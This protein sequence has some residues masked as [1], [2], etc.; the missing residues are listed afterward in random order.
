[1]GF[2]YVTEEGTLGEVL[3]RLERARFVYLDIETTASEDFRKS[4]VRLLQLGDDEETFVVDLFECPSCAQRLKEVLNKKAWVGHNLRFD[5]KHLYY[6]FGMQP[7]TTFDTY[8]AS[9]L[10]GNERNSLQAV[11]EKYLGEYL[12]KTEQTSNWGAS[13]LSRQQI[14]YA[15]KDVEILRRLFPILLKELNA[16]TSQRR[17][18]LLKTQ[19]AEIFGLENPVAIVEMAAVKHV[20]KLEAHGFALDVEVLKKLLKELK[21]KLQKAQI[22]FI[23]RYGK[24]D[25]FSSK[26]VAQFLTKRLGLSLPSTKKGNVSTDDKALSEYLEVP[27]VAEIVKIRKMKKTYDKIREL[28][29]YVKEDGRVYPEFKQIGAKTGR[30]SSSEP[31]VQNIPRDLRKIFK[32]PEGRLLVIADFSQIELRI[33]AEFVNEERMI[34]AFRR[35]EDMHV[36]T[37]SLVLGKQKDEVTKEERQLAKAMNYGLIYGISPRGLMEYAKFGYGV[38][39]SLEEAKELIKKFFRAFPRF[40]EW[41]KSLR[42]TLRDKGRVEGETLLGRRFVAETFQDAANYPIQG[43]GADILKLAV[44]IFGYQC[45][46]Q[47]LEARLVNLVH[48]EIVCEVPAEKAGEVAE[49]LKESMEFAGSLVLKKVPVEVETAVS[50]RWEK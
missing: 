38:D 29:G 27:A 6:H 12:D 17:P 41:H 47:G 28:A 13:V 33:A 48:D 50:E 45:E 3:K 35:G 26:Q 9:L 25:V 4:K 42:E 46:V 40:Y 14:E 43:T 11:V 18:E 7:L 8:I 32:A 21:L 31:N 30:M 15:A 24:I 44:D 20:A 36:L 5:V 16:A 22:D 49:L 10:L 2:T 19:V 39:V 34:E 23:T 37:A 1:M